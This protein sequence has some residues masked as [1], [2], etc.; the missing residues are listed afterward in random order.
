[1]SLKTYVTVNG[2]HWSVPELFMP[3]ASAIV[4]DKLFQ[5]SNSFGVKLTAFE[6]F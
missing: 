4:D 5:V 6:G 2:F 1:L 3:L